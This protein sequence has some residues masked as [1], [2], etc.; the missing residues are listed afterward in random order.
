VRYLRSRDRGAHWEPSRVLSRDAAGYPQLALDGGAV[1]VLWEHYPDPREPPRGLQLASSLDGGERFTR[2]ALV[3]GTRDPAG[4]GN[5]SFQGRF[6]HKLAVHRSTLAVAN[7]SL[8]LGKTSRVW[9]VRGVISR[10]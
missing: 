1:H 4:G 6:A 10:R 7:A 2:P 3:P 8:A 5:G 9:L